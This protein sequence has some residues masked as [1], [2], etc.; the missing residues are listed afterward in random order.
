MNSSEVIRS[1]PVILLPSYKPADVFIVIKCK[2]AVH[3]VPTNQLSV[4]FFFNCLSKY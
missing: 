2:H 1:F 4:S 3:V